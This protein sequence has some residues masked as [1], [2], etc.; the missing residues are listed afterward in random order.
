MI[1]SKDNKCMTTL[2]Y[3]YYKVVTV[4]STKQTNKTPSRYG[5]SSGTSLQTSFDIRRSF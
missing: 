3:Y 4:I 5:L 1:D 2:L